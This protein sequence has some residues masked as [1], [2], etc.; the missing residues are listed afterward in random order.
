M[1]YLESEKLFLE[2][3][4]EIE[5]QILYNSRINIPEIAKKLAISE[6][7]LYRKIK[8]FSGVTPIKIINV[9]RIYAAKELILFNKDFD[10][11]MITIQI[12]SN[13]YFYKLFAEYFGLTPKQLYD[14]HRK[15]HRIYSRILTFKSKEFKE[16]YFN[17]LKKD[18]HK[19]CSKH[20]NEKIG[21]I[22]TN[23]EM[24]KK[25]VSTFMDDTILVKR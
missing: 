14:T 23:S 5:N 2:F 4:N 3:V 12:E 25:W 24:M 11:V 22:L 20:I 8:D 6:R 18:F 10:D 21:F 17:S 19:F 7:I 15:K 13:A 1:W 16:S 9:L